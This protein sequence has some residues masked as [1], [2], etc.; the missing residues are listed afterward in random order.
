MFEGR[1]RVSASSN[2][3]GGAP[4]DEVAELN[5]ISREV[6]GQQRDVQMEARPDNIAATFVS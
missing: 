4:Q 3:H 1:L 5:S 6:G 2:H